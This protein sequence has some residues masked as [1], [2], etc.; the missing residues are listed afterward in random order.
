MG[1]C[2]HVCV[3]IFPSKAQGDNAWL[4]EDESGWAVAYHGTSKEGGVPVWGVDACLQ[5]PPAVGMLEYLHLF[6]QKRAALWLVYEAWT[7]G[8]VHWLKFGASRALKV[9]LGLHHQKRIALNRRCEV[10]TS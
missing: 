2:R 6:G 3:C 10:D 8:V 9:S 5:K 1:H 4:R 7:F